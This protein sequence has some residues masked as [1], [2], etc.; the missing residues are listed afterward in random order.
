MLDGL[1]VLKKFIRW[2]LLL[3]SPGAGIV[4]SF[5]LRLMATLDRRLSP[6]P[7]LGEPRVLLVD[8]FRRDISAAFI[9][10][11]AAREIDDDRGEGVSLRWR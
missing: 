8:E 1:P 3:S 5:R 7:I 11:A 9:V 2:S 10:A 4:G 6:R